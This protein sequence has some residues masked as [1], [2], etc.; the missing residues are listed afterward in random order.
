MSAG[1]KGMNR[2]RA[3]FASALCLWWAASVASAEVRVVSVDG[4]VRVA[5][6]HSDQYVS[7]VPGQVLAA[8][9]VVV[10]GPGGRATLSL[11]EGNTIRLRSNTRLVVQ[12]REPQRSRFKLLAGRLKGIFDGL[13][14]G[15]RV[16]LEFSSR[17][18][19]ASVKG[20]EFDAEEGPG[21]MTLRAFLGALEVALRDRLH[22]LPQGCGLSVDEGGRVHI[23]PLTNEEIADGLGE[24]WD[25]RGPRGELAGFVD[26][27][28]AEG[29]RDRALVFQI[30]EDDFAVG[31][32]LRDVH[33][34]LT[35][36]DQRLIRPDG[37]SVQF[38]NLVKRDSYR[39]GGKF[40]YTGPS[41]AR[42]DYLEGFVRFDRDLPANVADW[43]AF[44]SGHNDVKAVFGRV[45]LA[46]GR[47][48]DPGR[49]VLERTTRFDDSADAFTLN[50]R[51]FRIDR[52]V[53]AVE[54]DGSDAGDLWATSI[55]TAYWDDN[56]D[57]IVNGLDS[58]FQ[59]R[60]EGYVIDE[61]GRIMSLRDFTRD[62]FAD[63][64]G[65]A[66]STAAQGIFSTSGGYSLHRGNI[67][68]VVI[69]D[70]AVAAAVRYGPSLSSLD[71]GD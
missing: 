60:M 48:G 26:G 63:P 13:R 68:I 52:T 29:E 65:L 70:L 58:P 31:R 7:A 11:G 57:G 25:R 55:Q 30:R 43:P 39:Y 1:V 40:D 46:N 16:E 33:G 35:R 67:D 62:S 47:P 59:I 32:S 49:D 17:S 53:P 14:P 20:T 28:R 71:V 69:P 22:S 10:T 41:G 12:A 61:R 19:V 3:R 9:M 64:F 50:G 18:A 34:N 45:T 5:P 6:E 23:R 51:P 36:V 15:E 4:V 24:G 27:V 37:S 42:Y 66:L 2:T 44:F 56:R 54:S 38:V 8:G 21:E